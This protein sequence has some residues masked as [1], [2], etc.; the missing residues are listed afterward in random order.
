M[1]MYCSDKVVT[2][3]NAMSPMPMCLIHGIVHPCHSS[4]ESTTC[5]GGTCNPGTGQ[6]YT[7]TCES[8]QI[9]DN[10]QFGELILTL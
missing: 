6:A 4:I 10:C 1:L 7:C 3:L 9:G 2:I 8:G 5:N